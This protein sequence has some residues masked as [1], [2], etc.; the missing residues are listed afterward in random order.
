[1]VQKYFHKVFNPSLYGVAKLNNKNKISLIKEKPK[2]ISQ[3]MQLQVY[4]F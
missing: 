1:M 4:I 2:N 3:I